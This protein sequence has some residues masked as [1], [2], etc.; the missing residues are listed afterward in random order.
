MDQKT[1]T[2]ES[3]KIVFQTKT[4][5][6]LAQLGILLVLL[7]SIVPI[8][9]AQ[10]YSTQVLVVDMNLQLTS[11]Q[12]NSAR[13]TRMNGG[14]YQDTGNF[15]L[16][17]LDASGKVVS[18]QGFSMAFMS[19]ASD[20]ILSSVQTQSTILYDSKATHITVNFGAKEIARY[21]LSTF[22]CNNDGVCSGSETKYSCNDCANI[23]RDGVCVPVEDSYCDKDCPEG[24]DFD[25]LKKI[26]P[27][28]QIISDNNTSNTNQPSS[29]GIVEI[30]LWQIIIVIIVLGLIITFVY[31]YKKEMSNS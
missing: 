10:D 30:P 21:E 27:P 4:I 6:L 17:L 8:V 5:S 24:T 31:F 29:Q 15:S 26:T 18:A 7:I 20:E 16:N 13:L 28:K 9:F 19:T 23:E 3:K 22:L 12:I 11:A 1:I 2:I 25:C 14:L